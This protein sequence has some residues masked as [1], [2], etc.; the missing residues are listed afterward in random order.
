MH[1]LYVLIGV[2]VLLQQPNFPRWGSVKVYLYK[3]LGPLALFLFLYPPPLFVSTRMMVAGY[4]RPLEEKDLWSL[5]PE[6]CSHRVVPQLVRCWNTE[7]QKVK[8]SGAQYRNDDCKKMYRN[9]LHCYLGQTS[10]DLLY[11][12]SGIFCFPSVQHNCE[13]T[14]K[15]KEETKN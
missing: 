14:I 13:Q 8:R 15:F 11:V 9:V 7:C 4:K 12:G 10:P 2:I 6:D 3:H 5:N 1:D